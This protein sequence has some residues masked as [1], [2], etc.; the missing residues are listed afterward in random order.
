MVK[1]SKPIYICYRIIFNARPGTLP[2][3]AETTLTAEPK[4]EKI[5]IK[6]ANPNEPVKY[7]TFN[8]LNQIFSELTF[9]KGK[10]AQFL[11]VNENTAKKTK[12]TLPIDWRLAPNAT[13]DTTVQ[14]KR[15]LKKDISKEVKKIGD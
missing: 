3:K 1:K 12:V 5:E 2:E 11:I 13:G 9:D 7:L 6:Y 10:N 4:S 15:S 14:L 8:Q